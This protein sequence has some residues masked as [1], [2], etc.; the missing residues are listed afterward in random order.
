MPSSIK[1]LLKALFSESSQFSMVR[2]M[3]LLSLAVGSYIALYSVYHRKDLIG[4]AELC[5]VFVGGAF[6]G[7]VAQKFIENKE[8]EK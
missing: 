4:V 1:A 3:S 5:A 8:E 2:V 7:K 6:A